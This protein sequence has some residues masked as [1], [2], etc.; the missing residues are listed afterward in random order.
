VTHAIH[1][2]TRIALALAL[3][4]IGPSGQTEEIAN[5][6]FPFNFSVEKMGNKAT[7]RHD[8]ARYTACKWVDAATIPPDKL[9]VSSMDQMSNR[10]DVQ[11]NTVLEDAAQSASTA[12]MGSPL[13]QVGALYASGMDGPRLT[14]L[15]V[16]PLKEKFARI[17]A[18]RNPKALAQTNAY[19]G[20]VTN[21]AYVLASGVMPDIADRTRYSILVSDG[22]LGLDNLE[23]YL[24]PEYAGIREAYLK[25]ITD[26]LVIAGASPSVART[27]A[28]MVLTL[29]TR[30]ARVRQTP[31]EKTDPD[32]RFVRLSYAELK[33]L[34]PSFDWDVYFVEL[35]LKAPQEVIA[36]EMS[37]MRERAAAIAALSQDDQQDQVLPGLHINGELAVGENL[38]DVSGLSFAYA[39]LQKFLKQH[40]EENRKIDGFTPEQRCFI[41]W[42]QAWASSKTREGVTRQLAA[43]DPHPPGN[44]RAFAAAQHTPG[45]HRAFDIRPS[46]PM[47]LPPN[48]RVSIW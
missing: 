3:C 27:T 41:A 33:S 11:V 36:I 29:E 46:D 5:F 1:R 21:E 39:A 18:I 30:V 31:V 45:F 20:L 47:W 43:I 19:L 34:T 7:L 17:D 32:K 2:R 14:E 25:W 12:P 15:G 13:Q 48:D 4:A 26:A 9:R 16:S 38:A 42:G 24:K 23:H 6:G 37:T 35:G 10:V 28:D 8:F 22:M 44:Y 40:P